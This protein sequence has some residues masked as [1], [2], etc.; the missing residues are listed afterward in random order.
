MSPPTAKKRKNNR[1]EEARFVYFIYLQQ[2]VLFFVG[3][4]FLINVFNF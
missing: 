1:D 2:V 3:L 4:Y